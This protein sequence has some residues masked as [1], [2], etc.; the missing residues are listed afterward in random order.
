MFVVKAVL[1]FLAAYLLGSLN[2]SLVVGRL[3]GMDIRQHGS[4][5]AG[6][7]NTLRTL[8]KL[9]ALFVIVG[10]VLKGVLACIIGYYILKDTISTTGYGNITGPSNTGLLIGGL[11]A[12]IGHNWPVYF[13]FK[14]GKGILTTFAVIMTVS[15]R[16]GLILLLIF[17]VIV[18]ITRY[19]SLGSI[20]GSA[21]FPVLSAVFGKGP[22]F[23]VF[24]AIVAIMAIARH[25][26]NIGRLVKGTESKLGQKKE[27]GIA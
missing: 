12:I 9:P 2:T 1:V 11:G 25:H 23:V 8:G 26:S 7:T 3:Y 14:G 21:M 17:L 13:G 27:K 18:A 16:I 5:N 22:I 20:I 4:G 19:V 15:P 10:D 6:M 24:A